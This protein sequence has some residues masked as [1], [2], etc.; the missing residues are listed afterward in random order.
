MT[1]AYSV[2][3][4]CTDVLDIEAVTANTESKESGA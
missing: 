1:N 4:P 2:C 3:A